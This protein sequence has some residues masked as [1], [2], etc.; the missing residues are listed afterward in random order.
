MTTYNEVLIRAKESARDAMPN[1]PIQNTVAAWQ[2][3]QESVE[4]VDVYDAAHMEADSWDTVIYHYKAMVLCTDV[5][6]SVLHNAES[7]WD[8]CTDEK[9]AGLYE[10]ACLLAYWIVQAEL[11]DAMESLQA[12]LLELAENQIENLL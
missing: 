8:D 6:S 2:A 11:V 10:L 5:P 1:L 7:Q 4:A 3:F 12:E 9:P